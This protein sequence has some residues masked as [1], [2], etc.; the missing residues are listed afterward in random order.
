MFHS[1]TPVSILRTA[2]L[3]CIYNGAVT[4]TW[5]LVLYATM[6]LNISTTVLFLHKK[7]N[8]YKRYLYLG[9]THCCTYCTAAAQHM[10]S[11]VRAVHPITRVIPLLQVRYQ[12]THIL[13]RCSHDIMLRAGVLRNEER[14]AAMRTALERFRRDLS[15][16]V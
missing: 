15:V 11:Y 12:V 7:T 8:T 3:A 6:S 10:Y 1:F 4:G 16:G 2:R 13:G 5:Y 14:Y 9:T